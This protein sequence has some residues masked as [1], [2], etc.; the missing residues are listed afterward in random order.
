MNRREAE[1]LARCS[2]RLN[3]LS[4]VLQCLSGCMYF[5]GSALVWRLS[6]QPYDRT[7]A[8]DP[9]EPDVHSFVGFRDCFHVIRA[10]KTHFCFLPIIELEVLATR[11]TAYH[12]G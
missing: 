6:L 12:E 8:G 11:G 7:A 9:S 3:K 5:N 4:E 1:Y 2:A 10:S